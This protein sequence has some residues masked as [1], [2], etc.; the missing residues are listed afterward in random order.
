MIIKNKLMQRKI[1]KKVIYFIL[2]IFNDWLIQ[3][4]FI[5]IIFEKGEE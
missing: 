3:L 4:L 5:L 1:A 2:W